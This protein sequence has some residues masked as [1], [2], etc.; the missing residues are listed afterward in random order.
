MCNELNNLPIPGTIPTTMA[1]RER[2]RGVGGWKWRG[3][4]STERAQGRQQVVKRNAGDERE[5]KECGELGMGHR[6]CQLE[7]SEMEGWLRNYYTQ[8]IQ[9]T[10]YN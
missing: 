8:C 6:E 1:C 5:K 4:R 7:E 10:Q 9:V 3:G 2:K